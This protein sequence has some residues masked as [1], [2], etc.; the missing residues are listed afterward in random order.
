MA[1]DIVTFRN[2]DGETL[3][4]IIQSPTDGKRDEARKGI[5]LPNTG[6]HYRVAWHRLN[7]EL[8]A[9]LARKGFH[10]MRFD[11][12]GIGDSEGELDE[13]QDITRQ[14]D[15]IQ[16][17]LFARDAIR[18]VDVF[19]QKC[20]LDRV[21]LAGFCGGALTS[22]IAAGADQRVSGVIYIAGPVTID[23]EYD[24]HRLHPVYAKELISSY[25]KKVLKPSSWYRLLTGKSDY[26]LIR[27]TV[28]TTVNEKK[29]QRE[30]IGE[31]V[32]GNKEGGTFNWKFLESFKA[33]TSRGTPVLF[34]MADVDPATYGFENYFRKRY[35]PEGN[36]YQ[37]KFQ[38]HLVKQA[39][40]TFTTRE[41]RADLYGTIEAWLEHHG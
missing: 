40:H 37:G 28:A 35:L 21:Y 19:Q 36:S 25:L 4:G 41:S 18:A 1:G 33:C 26:R 32:E 23:S 16:Q 39:N 14:F 10:V 22:M 13:S 15:I 12:H 29:I 5:I 2:V 8:S 6:I 38:Y 7:V 9:R 34:I 24:V 31:D 11:P 17:G 27:Q 3:F 20:S 30:I